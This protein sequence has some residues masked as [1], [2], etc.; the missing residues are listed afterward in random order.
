MS[1]N[2][3]PA[4]NAVAN[5]IRDIRD[6]PKSEVESLYGITISDNFNI[7]DKTYNMKFNSVGEWAEF[8]VDQEN[9]EYEKHTQHSWDDEYY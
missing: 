7:F 9:S 5:I 3:T 8:S 1:R 2:R 6:L 4:A